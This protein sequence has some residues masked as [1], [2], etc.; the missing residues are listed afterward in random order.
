MEVEGET[1]EAVV[2]IVPHVVVVEQVV[3]ETVHTAVVETV[4]VVGTVVGFG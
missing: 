3:E 4:E 2:G 1:L